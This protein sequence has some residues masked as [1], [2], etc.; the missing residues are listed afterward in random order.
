[1]LFV[2]SHETFPVRALALL[3]SHV[4]H[5]TLSPCQFPGTCVLA[6]VQNWPWLV[7]AWH[8]VLLPCP[9]PSPFPW[10]PLT[11]QVPSLKPSLITPPHSVTPSV[12]GILCVASWSPPR[13]LC[14]C[15]SRLCPCGPHSIPAS[16]RALSS[17]CWLSCCPVHCCSSSSHGPWHMAGACTFRTVVARGRQL[18]WNGLW[19]R[20]LCFSSLSHFSLPGQRRQ[21]HFPVSL[22]RLGLW[23]VLANGL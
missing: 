23:P 8:P 17:Q 4:S 21:T 11:F 12:C 13:L 5:L 22:V 6:H 19:Q 9:C 16:H 14:I 10:L 3:V 18:G 20:P 2:C 7:L 15:L 1:M